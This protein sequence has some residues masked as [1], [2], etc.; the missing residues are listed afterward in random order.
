MLGLNAV[1]GLPD[2]ALQ[3]ARHGGPG[4]PAQS[5]GQDF[6][7]LLGRLAGEAAGALQQGEVAALAGIQ[8]SLPLQMVVDKVM[9]AERTLQAALAVRDKAVSA[10]QEISRMQI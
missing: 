4:T 10:Y 6:A 1:P 7:S 5:A 2:L 8:G 3:P 9:A